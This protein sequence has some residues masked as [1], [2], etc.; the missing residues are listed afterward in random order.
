MTDRY[1]SG[2]NRPW[3]SR[4]VT[5]PP[6][7]PEQLPEPLSL[8]QDKDGLHQGGVDTDTVGVYRN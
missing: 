4:V 8:H 7:K 2:P 6:P 1:A 5:F 3:P